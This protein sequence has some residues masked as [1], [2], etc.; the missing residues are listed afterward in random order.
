MKSERFYCKSC[1]SFF[2]EPK[3]CEERHGLDSPPYEK[4]AI[5]ARCGG[6]D[7][8]QHNS[9]VEKIE[10]AEKILSA[11]MYLNKY[12]N[13]LK[14]I[15]GIS[16]KNDELNCSV[17]MMVEAICEMFD[18]LDNDGER[19]LFRLCSEGELQRIL[20]RLKG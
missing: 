1:K 18:F 14:D 3:F 5:C 7:F 11:L 9:F 8:V 4:V 20:I 2:D 10:V 15:Y 19:Q 12:C 13:A 16:L 6:D 17:E